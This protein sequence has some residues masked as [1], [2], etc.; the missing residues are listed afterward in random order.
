MKPEG[1]P[2]NTERT[3]TTQNTMRAIVQATYGSA[4]VLRLERIATPK[5]ADS[6]VL[7]RVH[8]AG[9]D[10]G[11]WHLMTGRPYLQRG[12]RSPDATSPAPSSR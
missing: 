8:A 4:D 5:I 12:T 6:K 2:T 3:T 9:L 10:R 11:T 1:H 7:V